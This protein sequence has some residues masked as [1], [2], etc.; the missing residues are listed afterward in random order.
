MI[1]RT[2]TSKILA[3]LGA[4]AGA[5]LLAS[6]AA[7]DPAPG[8]A[9]SGDQPERWDAQ[10][11][12]QQQNA[13]LRDQAREV[14]GAPTTQE[15]TI[16]RPPGARDA[17]WTILMARI[18]DS[19]PELVRQTLDALRRS[20]PDARTVTREGSTFLAHGGYTDPQSS[21]ARQDLQ[22][23]R[24]YALTDKPDAPRP[25]AAAFMAPPSPEDLAGSNPN[26][27]LRNV[28][29]RF[30]P[31]AIYTL[32]IGIYGSTD[33]RAP[34]AEEL[35]AIRR[36]AEEAVIALRREGEQAFYYHAP[37]RSTVTVGVYGEDD[38]DPTTY[39]RYESARLRAARERH[40]LNLLNGQGINRIVRDAQGNRVRKPQPSFIVAIPD[41]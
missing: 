12:Q 28:K 37:S 14:L 40:P 21:Q 22:R 19:R 24:S 11:H 6:C 38:H 20:F 16:A 15:G 29:E 13:T 9:Q 26:Y 17:R 36:A 25:Y 7:Q 31:D 34:S 32:Q 3:R 1:I 41:E 27:D 33:R 39:P 2:R 30:G 35:E 10:V 4:L 23:I 5:L 18:D 8:A